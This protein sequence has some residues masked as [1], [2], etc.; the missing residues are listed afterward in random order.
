MATPM[1][2]R[3]PPSG[4]GGRPFIW[5]GVTAAAIAGYYYYTSQGD[6]TKAKNRAGSDA[7][8]LREKGLDGAESIGVQIDRGYDDIKSKA[9]G[10]YANAK[11]EFGKEWD[12]TNAKRQEAGKKLE[13]LVDKLDAKADEAA[14][15][16]KDRISN[17]FGKK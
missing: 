14:A 9:S 5:I 10:E 11:K 7:R 15:A 16:A 17:P 2:P 6:L 13:G 1:P 8:K 3:G 4:R 12:A